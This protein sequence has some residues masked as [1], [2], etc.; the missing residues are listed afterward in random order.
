MLRNLLEASNSTQ[1]RNLAREVSPHRPITDTV[2]SL[3]DGQQQTH[4]RPQPAPGLSKATGCPSA[5]RCPQPAWHRGS[6]G[7]SLKRALLPILPS[8]CQEPGSP[9]HRLLLV[10]R[11]PGVG[12]V[13]TVVLSPFPPARARPRVNRAPND[14]WPAPPSSHALGRGGGRHRKWWP[15][16]SA[17]LFFFLNLSLSW[18]HWV[19]VGGVQ[20]LQFLMQDFFCGGHRLS[21][22][23]G[24][25]PECPGSIAVTCRLRSSEA[26]G[27]L[28]PQP[29]IEPRS[30][31]FQGGFLTT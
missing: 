26:C 12:S 9:A 30:S 20:N 7:C 23:G 10:G 3:H 14:L 8:G 19:L 5:Q 17:L 15:P 31:I 11:L 2:Y 27:I 18:L 1:T 16:P 24:W 25:P 13:F 29:G 21:S 6:R 4:W 28:V 22:C